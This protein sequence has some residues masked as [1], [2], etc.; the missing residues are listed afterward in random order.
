MILDHYLGDKQKLIIA[1]ISGGLWIYNRKMECYDLLLRK[2]VLVVL[3]VMFWVYLYHLD[4]L[5]MPIG[6][7]ILY[8]IPKIK[9]L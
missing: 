9:N 8:V 5:F 1:I 2:N 7:L 3:M 4:K 6:L